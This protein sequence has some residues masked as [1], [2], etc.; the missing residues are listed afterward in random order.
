MEEAIVD[1]IQAVAR[2][3]YFR[4]EQL[5]KAR[6]LFISDDAELEYLEDMGL[7][8]VR[9]AVLLSLERSEEAAELHLSEGRPLQAIPLF[10]KSKSISKAS[11]CIAS[12]IWRHISFGIVPEEEGPYYQL[13]D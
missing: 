10:L 8:I 5:Q 4:E 3:H 12:E 13:L 7:D 9:A 2:L 1:D 6:E 11:E